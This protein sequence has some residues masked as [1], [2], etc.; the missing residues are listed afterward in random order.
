MAASRSADAELRR[1]D[2]LRHNA[3]EVALRDF[4]GGYASLFEDVV[5]LESEN[6][7]RL[8]GV[9][10]DLAGQVDVAKRKAQE[11]RK[12]AKD[13]AE[14][15]VR[16]TEREERR[17]REALLGDIGAAIDSFFD[18]QPSEY[19][20][21]PPSISASF[22]TYGRHRTAGDTKSGTS[23][24]DPDRLRTFVAQA[25]SSNGRMEAELTRVRNSWAGF[26]SACSW[27]PVASSTFLNG[28]ARLLSE[29]TEDA[30]WIEGVAIAFETAGGASLSNRA[31]DLAATTVSPM[32]DAAL[33][34]ALASLSETEL[35][36]LF[37]ASPGLQK[38]VQRMDPAAIN[39]WW[40]DMN[41]GAPF[42]D[43]QTLLLK[44]LPVL[45]GNLEGL[46]YGARDYANRIALE[47]AIAN[48]EAQLS[49]LR[50]ALGSASLS[51]GPNS[52]VLAS[53]A[54]AE[55]AMQKQ[56]DALKNIM[57]AL[58]APRSW[59]DRYVI[60]LTEHQPP[61]AA[62]SI[63]DLDTATSI[64]YAIPGMGTTTTG[65]TGWTKASQ[66]LY[67]LLPAGSA[68]VSWI[69]YETPPD[70]DLGVL[71]SD[72]AVAGGHKLATTLRGLSAARA[73]S[74]P[75]LHVVA[76]SY[77]STTAAITLSQADIHVNT[78]IAIGSAGLPD[79]IRTVAD[80]N[81]DTVYSGQARDVYPW[82][83]EGGDEWAWIGRDFSHDHHVNPISPEFGA[84][85]FG[86]ESG[87][88][89]GRPVTS[90]SV[91]KGNGGD[92]AGYLDEG[93][94]S[95][96]NAAWAISGDSRFITPHMPLGP[97]GFQKSVLEGSKIGH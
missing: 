43:Q 12:R 97:T 11:E 25:R 70:S 79:S 88:D 13:L 40:N 62:I 34:A 26:V 7:A 96:Q 52:S 92:E 61:L 24:A 37:A 51:N 54:Q 31:L 33:L 56:L 44:A 29:S 87:G 50:N 60:S 16:E 42:S 68:V 82:E 27:I 17:R 32:R 77:G 75:Q 90:H 69:G 86:V 94:E 66:N 81:A 65:M 9:L 47:A 19:A 53:A 78:F 39:E 80:L 84:H 10:A 5:T 59:G 64:T 89:A 28:F 45:F 38:Q 63:G 55:A 35:L 14:W 85:A 30:T 48:V 49:D 91:L 3:A 22:T 46:P 41:T 18:P 83:S 76:H 23:S 74:T 36:A 4:A 57:D 2:A 8:A 21:A 72:R 95:L 58:S 73:D 1:Q 71:D 6:R 67:G 20:I 93:T 15:R